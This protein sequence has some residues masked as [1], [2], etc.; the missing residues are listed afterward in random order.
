MTAA[1]LADALPPRMDGADAVRLFTRPSMGNLFGLLA[2]KFVNV[3]P[4]G[5]PA[6]PM[7]FAERLW[8]PAYALCF[9]VTIAGRGNRDIWVSVCAWSGSFS[10]F[11]CLDLLQP[12]ETT[13]EFFPAGITPE[14]AH[15]MGRQSFLTYVLRRRGQFNKPVVESVSETRLYHAPYWVLYTRRRA[16]LDLRVIDGYSGATCGP[17]LKRG[18]LDAL[19]ACRKAQPANS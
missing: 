15:A 4:Q 6:P 19:I 7:P 12:L 13:E 8:M 18:I 14:T 16:G 11:E 17:K 9:N 3:R 1:T 2:P 10:L 5:A